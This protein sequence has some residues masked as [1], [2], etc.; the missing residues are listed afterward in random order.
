MH[1][2]PFGTGVNE[3]G[4]PPNQ[5]ITSSGG[6]SF[7]LPTFSQYAQLS[8]MFPNLPEQNLQF[9]Y[10]LSNGAVSRAS[11]C[12][13][14]GPSLVSLLPLLQ[15]ATMKN[16][17]CRLRISEDE[18]EGEFSRTTRGRNLTPRLD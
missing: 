2:T 8:Q 12:I 4:L 6:N 18:E 17:S 9:I 7:H 11:E 13:L 15:S 3:L 14:E 5:E 1:A 10:N 16:D